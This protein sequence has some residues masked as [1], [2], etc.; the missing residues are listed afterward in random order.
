M[1]MPSR[2]GYVTA[3]DCLHPVHGRLGHDYVADIL[4]GWLSTAA[5][6]RRWSGTPPDPDATTPSPALLKA[7]AMQRIKRRE[8]EWKSMGSRGRARRQRLPPPLHEQN[9][10]ANAGPRASCYAFRHPDEVCAR[11]VEY[12]CGGMVRVWGWSRD[13]THDESRERSCADE[14]LA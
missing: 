13:G 9:R 5:R 10:Q 7:S 1:I 12:V 6:V 8:A 14:A 4:V 11:M 3:G 2:N